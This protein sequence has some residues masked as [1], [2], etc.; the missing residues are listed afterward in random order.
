MVVSIRIRIAHPLKNRPKI[1][2]SLTVKAN[3]SAEIYCLKLFNY[4]KGKIF[5]FVLSKQFSLP[6]HFMTK[7]FNHFLFVE[8]L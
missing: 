3:V 7:T 5:Y 8:D 4:Q 1:L 6:E 2:I